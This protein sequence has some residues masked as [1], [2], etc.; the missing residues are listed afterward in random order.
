MWEVQVGALL[1]AYVHT[2]PQ[3]IM[4]IGD[5][6]N[7]KGGRILFSEFCWFVCLFELVLSVGQKPCAIPVTCFLRIFTLHLLPTSCYDGSD[8]PQIC[9]AWFIWELVLSKAHLD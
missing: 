4:H 3:S 1:C 8:F 7:K 5:L 9:E 6:E 2:H